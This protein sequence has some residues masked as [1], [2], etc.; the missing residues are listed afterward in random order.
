MKWRGSKPRDSFSRLAAWRGRLRK[1]ALC[2]APVVYSADNF[3][4]HLCCAAAKYRLPDSRSTA[5]W[6]RKLQPKHSALTLPPRPPPYHAQVIAATLLLQCLGATLVAAA[7]GYYG[8]YGGGYFTDE[9]RYSSQQ[10]ALQQQAGMSNAPAAV[11]YVRSLLEEIPIA[12]EDEA[13]GILSVDRLLGFNLAVLAEHEGVAAM[14]PAGAAQAQPQQGGAARRVPLPYNAGAVPKPFV[15]A[16]A[17][18]VTAPAAVPLLAS[19]ASS[20]MGAVRR[21]AAGS[22]GGYYGGYGALETPT[23]A[24]AFSL[25]VTYQEALLQSMSAP[26]ARRLVEVMAEGASFEAALHAVAGEA[27]AAHGAESAAAGGYYGGYYGMQ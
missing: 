19:G 10:A 27:A 3:H 25:T 14:Q 5:C 15:K 11:P 21:E 20:G 16:E 1:R 17:S 2:N 6:L 24:V 7:G 8:Q 4:A 13:A 12:G 22:Y 26:V 18:A 9:E 23:L